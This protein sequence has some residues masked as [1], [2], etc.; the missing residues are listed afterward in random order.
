VVGLDV[1][2]GLGVMVDDETRF[3]GILVVLLIYHR[4]EEM[5]WKAPGS[6]IF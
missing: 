2:W 4:G 5:A 1:V 6:N 3:P